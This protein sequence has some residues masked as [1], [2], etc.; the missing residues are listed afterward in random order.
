[1]KNSEC[2]QGDLIFDPVQN[3]QPVKSGQRV[4]VVLS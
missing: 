3:A 1:M 4:N 2:Q